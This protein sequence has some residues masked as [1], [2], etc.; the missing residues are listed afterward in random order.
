[1][2]CFWCL[3]SVAV[4]VVVG[5]VV[6]I[7]VIDVVVVVVDPRNQPLKFG[8]NWPS[9]SWDISDIHFCGWWCAVIFVSNPNFGLSSCWVWAVTNIEKGWQNLPIVNFCTMS[10][11][12]FSSLRTYSFANIFTGLEFFQPLHKC[13]P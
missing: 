6:V 8:W 5:I 3:F 13:R 4:F 11:S 9:N 12:L 2:R 10:S 1:M 7:V